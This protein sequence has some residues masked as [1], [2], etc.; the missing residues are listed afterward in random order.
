MFGSTTILSPSEKAS[1]PSPTPTT[2]PENSWPSVTPGLANGYSPEAMCRSVPQSPEA[3]T[4]TLNSPGPGEGTSLDSRPTP[5]RPSHTTLL[6]LASPFS[7]REPRSMS[8]SSC[9]DA[10]RAARGETLLCVPVEFDGAARRPESALGAPAQEALQSFPR[11]QRPHRAVVGAG[12][13]PRRR[14][15]AHRLADRRLVG[16]PPRPSGEVDEGCGEEG[17]P[18]AGGIHGPI[19]LEAWQG[20]AEGPGRVEGPFAAHAHQHP[21]GAT[22][23]Q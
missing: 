11:R 8:L 7:V 17:V 5:S 10:A 16:G 19:D 23:Q 1:A 12:Q 14:A 4:L 15:P 6:V 9:R 13:G 18:R 2:V 20:A 3:S 21:V 22:G